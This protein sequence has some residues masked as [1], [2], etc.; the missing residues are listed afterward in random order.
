MPVIHKLNFEKNFW[1]IMIFAS[2]NKQLSFNIFSYCIK[3]NRDI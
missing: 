3:N 2:S 1:V